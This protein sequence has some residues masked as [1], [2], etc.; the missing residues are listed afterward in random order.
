MA[1][2]SLLTLN[3]YGVPAPGTSERL[4]LLAHTLNNESHTAVCLQEVQSN[5]YRRLLAREC[6][7]PAHAYEPFIHAPKGGLLTLVQH[8]IQESRF[9]LYEERGLWYTP[10][11]ADWILHKGIL[12]THLQVGDLP[13]VLMNTHLTANY[14]GDWSRRNPFARHE[15]QQLQQ[16]AYL[17]Q[18]QPR[19][20]LV[21][22]CGDF[23]I[24]RGSWLYESFLET[25][26]LCDP[27]N[28]DMQPT[29]KPRM[30]MPSRYVMPIDFALVRAP[31]YRDIQVSSRLR[32][33]KEVQHR[34]KQLHL[35]DHCGVELTLS[36]AHE[37][38]LTS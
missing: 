19:E 2:F 1:N 38:L 14:T 31:Y 5:R 12:V 30:I 16:L 25:S 8:P 10:A 33:Q 4:K 13:V 17:V 24:P 29:L 11:L 23:N 34:G 7:F 35:S 6:H 22:V 26:G 3:C 32:F 37:T 18:A 27:L 20:A 15:H 36:W 9:V 21:V 28:G